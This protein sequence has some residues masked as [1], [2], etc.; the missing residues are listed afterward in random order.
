[1][2]TKRLLIVLWF[3]LMI[4]V[5]TRLGSVL[6][7][8]LKGSDAPRPLDHPNGNRLSAEL[9]KDNPGKPGFLV[10]I[11][12]LEVGVPSPFPMT[13]QG[14]VAIADVDGNVLIHETVT[15]RHKVLATTEKMGYP[16]NKSYALPPGL[17]HVKLMAFNRDQPLWY[18]DG[19]P[20][21]P[22]S[23]GRWYQVR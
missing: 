15:P 8:Q 3:A 16:V 6:A 19:S 14:E 10:V 9:K 11:G 12:A 21:A 4:F 23:E 1:M 13:L 20:H 7:G 22:A 5:G 17:Y 18:R 2:R